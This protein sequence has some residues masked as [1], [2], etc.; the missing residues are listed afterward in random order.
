MINKI[1]N[2]ISIHNGG[3]I[4]YLSM[5]H[6]EM[7]RK[8]NLILLDYRAKN[9]LQPFLNA[10]IKFFKR[11]IFRNLFVL[12]ERI[13]YSFNFK[14]FSNKKNQNKF[15]YEY[16]LNGLPPFFR[17]S[18]STNKVLILFQNKNLFYKLNYFDKNKFFKLNFLIYHFLHKMLIH[19]FI[20][21]TDLIIVQT[22]SMKKIISKYRPQ[23]RILKCEK[24]WKNVNIDFYNNYFVNLKFRKQNKLISNL[25]DLAKSN[26]LFFYPA[27]LDPHKNHKL[28]LSS[29]KRIFRDYPNRI[30]L[31]L[32]VDPK[33][34]ARDLHQNKNIIFIRNPSLNIIFDIYGLANYLI[35]PSLNESLG[36]PLIEARINKLPIIASDLDYVY[37]VCVPAYTFDPYSKIDIY[38]T[39]IKVIN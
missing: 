9:N 5:M 30:K 27:S 14:R 15:F 36:L 7:D 34:I 37:D 8:G 11:N 17:F 33:K 18:T 1:Y 6:S 12:K 38:E 21:E 31:I 20:K 19:T 10:E 23:N 2:C 4:V 3:G 25:K 39:I 16:Y 29:F 22:N 35:F 28:L 26:I 32:T 13:Y 24:Y